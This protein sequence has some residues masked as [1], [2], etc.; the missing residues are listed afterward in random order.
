MMTPRERLLAPFRGIVPDCPAWVAD[1]TYWHSAAVLRGQLDPRYSAPEGLKQLHLDL[2]VCNYYNYGE[3]AFRCQDG[4]V[5]CTVEEKD[6]VR[7][8]YWRTPKG[9]LTDR[10]RFLPEAWCWAHEEYA[11]KVVADF[12]ALR[13][14]FEQ[15]R[16]EPN[17]EALARRDETVGEDGLPLVPMPR[18]PLPSL[19]TDWCGVEQTI[20][21]LMDAPEV[22]VETLAAI[23]RSNDAAIA[24]AV[25]G[26][27]VL[28]HF[29]DN[30]DSS[31]STSFFDNHM[32]A[33]YQKRLTQVH[34]AGK[35]AVVHLDGRVRGLLRKLVDCGF[36]GIESI[37]PA[38]VGDVGIEEVRA[39]A[40]NDRVVLWGGVPGAM[41]A[42]P[43]QESEACEQAR[44]VVRT[45]ASAGRV[46]VGSA[47]QIPPDGHVEYCRAIAQ[48]IRETGVPQPTR[49]GRK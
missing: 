41:F 26:P 7:Q 46:V 19:L 15:R 45:W 25:D 13:C 3:S 11:V 38:P 37:T 31:A 27:A 12:A 20:Y 36:D 48:T 23:D 8:R 42:A 39:L 17:Y 47:D 2:G 40:G 34:Q 10:W 30:L 49:P 5:T 32:R 44:Q 33:Y 29:C 4:E 43:W 35:H 16:Y 18:S 1:L 21:F 24:I 22:V 28:F 6:G 9:M 14:I